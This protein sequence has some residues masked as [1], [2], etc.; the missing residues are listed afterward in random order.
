[1]DRNTYLNYT[2]LNNIRQNT[3]ITCTGITNITGIG[4]KNKNIPLNKSIELIQ[5]IYGLT[6]NENFSSN[7]GLVESYTMSVLQSVL[8]RSTPIGAVRLSWIETKDNQDNNIIM[9]IIKLSIIIIML[10]IIIIIIYNFY[11]D[12]C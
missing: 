9:L 8:I 12:T 10:I 1:M 4:L 7:F 6:Y 3:N 2:T 11:L 5:I